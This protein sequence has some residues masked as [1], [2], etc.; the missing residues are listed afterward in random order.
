MKRT[1]VLSFTLLFVTSYI[2]G[3]SISPSTLN[4]TGGSKV[5]GTDT[6]EW[7]VA[8]M[9][10]VNTASASNIIV[11]QGV[12]QPAP[13]P[14]GIKT[15]NMLTRSLQV[16]PNPASHIVYLQYNFPT[17]G[18]LNYVLQDITG[19]LISRKEIATAAGQNKEELNLGGLANASYMLYISYEPTNGTVERTSFKLDKIN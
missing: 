18:K 17:T 15:E 4:G 11:T 5:I 12:L 9:T 14:T 19:K 10:L 7:S 6:Y 1:I 2:R 8:E 13:P 3:Q 16:Y